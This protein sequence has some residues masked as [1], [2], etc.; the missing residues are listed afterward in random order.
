[1]TKHVMLEHCFNFLKSEEI[2]NEIKEIIKPFLNYIL[3]EISLYLY[4]FVFLIILSFMLH[5]G[6][7]ILLINYN[8]KLNIN[9]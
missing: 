2:K 9:S 6:I 1:M 4:F 8:K 7:L 5:L 3:K